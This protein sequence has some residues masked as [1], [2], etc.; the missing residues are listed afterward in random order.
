MTTFLGGALRSLEHS[1][2]RRG[3]TR[4]SWAQRAQIRAETLSRLFSRDDCELGTLEQL[5][6]A[7]DW[8]LLLVER[9]QREMP[10]AWDRET[11]H[12]VAKLCA[13]GSTDV[14]RWLREGPRY[15]MSGLAM[16]L[17][18]ARDVDRAAYLAL[19]YALCPAMQEKEEFATWLAM[20]PAKP[21][22]FLPMV[23]SLRSTSAPAHG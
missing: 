9:P 11:E 13:S 4:A 18:S 20:T 3:L 12:R 23:R 10:P 5:A 1:A 16:M 21:S 14:G 22:R 15:F 19:A 17:A 2:E 7:L 6:G 8:R